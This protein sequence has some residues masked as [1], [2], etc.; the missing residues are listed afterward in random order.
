MNW[1]LKILINNYA[2]KKYF[3]I[4]IFSFFFCDSA[5]TAQ[6]F[7]SEL[8]HEGRII[9]VDGDTIKGM[10]KYDLQQDLLQ[11]TRDDKTVDAFTARKVLFFEIFDNSVHLYRQFYALPY[12]ISSSYHAPVFFELL[13]DGTMTLLCREALEYRTMT[14]N[15]AGYYGPSFTRLVLVN[16]FFILDEKGNI[17]PFSGKKN[18]LLDLMG[19]KAEI[20]QKFMRTHRLRVEE[21]YDL[22]KIVAYYNSLNK[23]GL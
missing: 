1:K 6:N 3:F 4:V 18:E 9:L 10:I 22:A 23:R 12:S 2:S 21:K 17:S 13:V 5:I 19:K 8:W 16:S 11:L 20:V 14:Y 15:N 7:P